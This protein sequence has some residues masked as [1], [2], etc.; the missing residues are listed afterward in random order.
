VP[1]RLESAARHDA[2]EEP[3]MART[4]ITSALP[5][6]NG[7]I[8]L[9]HMVE[10]IQTDVMA[11]YL[12]LEGHEVLHVCA[13][14]THGTPI[15]LNARKQGISPEELVSRSLEEHRRDFAGFHIGF[16]EYY[17][18]NSPENEELAGLIYG[19]LRDAGHLE[20]RTTRQFYSES[21]GRFL[22]DRLVRGTCPRCKSPDQY[23]DACEVCNSTYEPTELIDPVDA[24]E[25]KTP[26]LRD[27][28]QIYVRLSDFD[29]VLRE[30][31]PA[32]VPQEQVRN[33]VRP[34]LDGGLEA[35]CISRDAPYFGFPI[36][37]EPGKYFYVWLDAPVGYVAA[38]RHW[39]EA[40]GQD[41]RRWW[42][43]DADT[44][45]IHVI[46]KDIVYFHTLFWPAMLHAARLKKPSRVHV[47]GFLTVNGAKMSKS[48]GTFV[49]AS[50]YLEHL[51]PDYLRFYVAAKLS[52]GV[53][54]IDLNL[55]DFVFRT[56]AD[57][58]NN[59]VNLCSRTT[60]FIEQKLEGRVSPVD[61]AHPVVQRIAGGLPGVR[62][63][64]AAWDTRAAVRRIN[65]LGDVLNLYF[66]E[67]EPWRVFSEGD[68]EGARA[69]CSVVLHGAIALMTALSPIV[70]STAQKLADCIGVDALRWEHAQAA[71]TPASVRSEKTFL[72]RMDRAW[73]DHLI[74]TPTPE[75][76]AA[77]A[78]AAET[79]V[80]PE[81]KPQISIDDF[82]KIDLRVGVVRAAALVE[83]ANKLL[84][85]TVDIGKEINV[86]A[87]VR[88]AYA[89][90]ST[91]VGKHVIVVANLAPRQ[92]KF[93]LSEGMLLA[94]SAEDD[95]GL[96]LAIVDDSTQPGWTVR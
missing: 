37:G 72:A 65:D 2:G 26:V 66:Q 46:G 15:E 61:P 76:A 55:D 85:L 5:Y 45:V 43:E 21:L 51:H 47:H 67:Q 36:P 91:L 60:K 56:N 25:G 41:W 10:H 86:F 84:Q 53:E 77:P 63:A 22:P 34:W 8:H 78:P 59:V 9:G 69:I 44:D 74:D 31:L 58:V 1:A 73:V 14:D 6:A 13:D 95:S 49:L 93:G 94:T 20:R 48:R 82:A 52:E 62:E 71:F 11:R 3:Q 87:G 7:S 89:D 39:C 50:R 30:W 24:I 38:T 35:W 17:T 23:G 70:P 29:G 80:T 19:A 88:K 18:T 40:H 54:D 64:Y 92:M 81:L 27:T 28:D 32:G 75:P 42:A 68:V 12:R 57:L 33:F 79:T 90:P 96:Q 16:D 4:L 83:G